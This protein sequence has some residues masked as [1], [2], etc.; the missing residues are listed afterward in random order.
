MKKYFG[1][2]AMILFLASCV[3]P[4]EPA[5][6]YLPDSNG[7]YGDILVLMDDNLWNG[8][9]GDSVRKKLTIP[10]EGPYLRRE[11]MFN[12]SQN[13]PNNLT[14]L[15]KLS[16]NILKII[17]DKDSTYKE[18]AYDEKK[19]VYAKNQLFVVIKDSDINRLFAF[20]SANSRRVINS[21]NHHATQ[22]L[23]KIYRNDSHKALNTITEKEYGISIA[24]PAESVIKSNKNG[25]ILVKR[26]R[27]R[28]VQANQKN[29]AE[30]GTFWIQQGFLF[31]SDPYI[32]DSNQ[33]TVENVL[34]NRDTTLKYNVPGEVKGTYMGTEYTE[35]Y[36]PEGRVFDFKGNQAVE[37][38]GLWIYDGPVFV[39]GGGPFVQYSILNKK[40]N[41]I[42]TVCGY[43][44][45]PSFEKRE[46]IRELDAILNSIEV[47]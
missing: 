27:S 22:Q 42:V 24:V 23:S 17:V 47:N 15:S 37:I 2:L 12:L 3:D 10:A 41:R 5:D 8:E 45:G 44:Y 18:T 1:L 20:F 31:W 29:R 35:Y 32:A 33:L 28:D 21:F 46:Y 19:N 36:E 25:F 30:G 4:N 7:N 43:V 11:P 38:R 34:K 26:D 6:L 13:K 40:T 39:G 16:R 9:F 14:H